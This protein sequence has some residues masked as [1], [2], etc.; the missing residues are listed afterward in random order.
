MQNIIIYYF[1]ATGNTLKIAKLYRDAMSERGANVKLSEITPHSVAETTK[2]DI[3]GIAYPVHGFRTPEIVTDFAKRLG[4]A[5]G[6]KI[7]FIKTSGEPLRLNDASGAELKRITDGQG[8]DF[9]G[10]YHYIMPYNMVFRHSDGMAARMLNTAKQRVPA[11]AEA[12]LDGKRVSL[13]A[14]ISAKI[15]SALCLIERPGM[16]LNGRLYRVN[17]SK[18]VKCMACVK[19]C[20]VSNIRY[21]NGKFSF[22]GNCIG[23]ARCAFNCPSNALT[24]GLLNAIKVNG[25]YDFNAAEDTSLPRYCKRSYEKYFAVDRFVKYED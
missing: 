18:C 7:F 15:M 24:T 23:C 10:E 3:V 16:K 22:G 9:L 21:E 25:R 20:P 2:Y 6:S 8:Y 1:S 13:S 11:H 14:P 4:A 19:N 12:I 17:A 5:N